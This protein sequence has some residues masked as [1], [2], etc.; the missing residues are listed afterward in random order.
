MMDTSLRRWQLSGFI[1]T[2]ITGTLLHFVYDWS[3]KN[4]L[5]GSISAVNESVW[6]HMKLLFIPLFLFALTEMAIFS[7]HHQCFWRIKLAG[8]LFGLTL[9]PTIFYTYTGAF[10]VHLTWLDISIYYFAAALVF[11]LETR[12]FHR[13]CR[14]S[15]A[16]EWGSLFL[17]WVLAFAFLLFTY[18][19]PHLPLFLDPVTFTYG[20]S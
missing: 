18:A 4:S 13:C 10:G 15:A 16:W 7:D 8:T 3:G 11:L 9:I 19:P 17:L 5:L 14:S 12:L 1:F 6:E 20:P 2:C